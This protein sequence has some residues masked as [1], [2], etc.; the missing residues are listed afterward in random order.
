[1][2]RALLIAGGNRLRR[3]DGVAHTVLERLGP[4]SDV[5]SRALLQLTPEVAED[6]AGYDTVI[7]IDADAGAAGVS[8]EP[9]NQPPQ[10]SSL[11][12]VSEP[13]EIVELSKALFGF[14]G[15]AF[16]CRIPVNDFSPGEGLSRRANALAV[17]A[18]R[19]LETL[20]GETR[21]NR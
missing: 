20:L 19:K 11:T 4:A 15:R 17:Q 16:L 10:P 5:E 14:A 12:H 7:F 9:V 6:I 2:P 21:K 8:I 3:D 18:A 1:M 13:A